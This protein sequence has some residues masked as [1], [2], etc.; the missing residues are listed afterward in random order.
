MFPD[1]DGGRLFNKESR[2]RPRGVPILFAFDF[3]KKS[4]SFQLL[5]VSGQ[6]AQCHLHFKQV[7]L[8]RFV[9]F[10]ISVSSS[11]P[12]AVIHSRCYLFSSRSSIILSPGVARHTAA[13]PH[14][15][16][17]CP[18]RT[19]TRPP[20]GPQDPDSSGLPRPVSLPPK[21]LSGNKEFAFF[22]LLK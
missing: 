7:P 22:F 12:D 13:S 14:P 1:P 16:F 5:G 20:P 10:L 3:F 9:S 17:Q 11:F 18:P 15:P 4:L 19:H 8:G 6:A 2:I 21:T